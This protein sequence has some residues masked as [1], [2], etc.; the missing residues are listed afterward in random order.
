MRTTPVL[1]KMP[2]KKTKNVEAPRIHFMTHLRLLFLGKLTSKTQ[3]NKNPK[4]EA[5]LVIRLVSCY[6]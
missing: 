6:N 2:Q 1:M 3:K 4:T 5:Y